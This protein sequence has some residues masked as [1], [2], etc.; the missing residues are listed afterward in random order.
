MHHSLT[1]S[2]NGPG[3][4]PGHA[5]KRLLPII[6]VIDLADG[7]VVHAVS[8]ARDRYRPVE[9]VHGLPPE[10]QSIG[11]WLAR[12][13]E[14]AYVADLDAIQGGAV[15]WETIETLARC[16]LALW[17]DAGWHDSAAFA[18]DLER[19]SR[20]GIT[21]RPVIASESVPDPQHLERILTVAHTGRRAGSPHAGLIGDPLV[22]VDFRGGQPL[23][24]AY[25]HGGSD[26]V[27]V[28][29]PERMRQGRAGH[30][31]EA[32]G[33]SK[34]ESE[35]AHAWLADWLGVAVGCGV[36]EAIVLDLAWVG[37]H[38]GL[39]ALALCQQIRRHFPDVA[40]YPGG[41]VR[42]A[43]DVHRAR[44]FGCAGVLVA[45]AL[46]RGIL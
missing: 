45:T 13:F 28:E 22:S 40:L 26:R 30:G 11:R 1:D 31:P 27:G 32:S 39:G 29:A 16:G 8:G 34:S 21:L 35:P 18:A 10:P 12:R 2:E 33:Q 20:R 41:G 15:Q 38:G 7:V 36:R 37:T 14:V 24:D 19:A 3:L 9:G 23:G 46:H 25:G 5:R 17:L 4:P 44:R 42:D 43:Q 6:P